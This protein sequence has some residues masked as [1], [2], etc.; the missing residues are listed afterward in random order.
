MSAGTKAAD[1]GDGQAADETVR[2][3]HAKLTTHRADPVSFTLPVDDRYRLTADELSWRI[4]R[5][6]GKHWRAIEW[7]TSIEAAVNSL[8]ARLLRTS[9]VQTL[10]D[11]L[12]AVEN[13]TRALTL[14][15]APSFK[16]ERRP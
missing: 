15:L 11:A 2:T 5:R 13:V 16:V 14:A 3:E 12:A 6:K 4:E 7:H 8:G 10:A 9:D 1:R